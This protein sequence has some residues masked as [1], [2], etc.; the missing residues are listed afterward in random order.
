MS[1]TV[2]TRIEKLQ[3]KA[4]TNL[5]KFFQYADELLTKSTS[6]N[7]DIIEKET[8]TALHLYEEYFKLLKGTKHELI[9]KSMQIKF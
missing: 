4:E 3:L 6:K 9:Y 8:G 1:N 7:R 5:E 2:K